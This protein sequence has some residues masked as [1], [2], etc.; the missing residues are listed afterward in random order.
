MNPIDTHERLTGGRT[1]T[2]AF[3]FVALALLLIFGSATQAQSSK[4]AGAAY[5]M[6][7]Q[8]DGNEIVAYGR[9]R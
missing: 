6:S 1:R 8:F 9:V 4:H 2:A 3:V 7:N 5:A